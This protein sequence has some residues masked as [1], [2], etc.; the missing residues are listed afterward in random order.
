MCKGSTK[1]KLEAMVSLETVG[2]VWNLQRGEQDLTFKIRFLGVLF[3][4]VI[5]LQ[6]RRELRRQP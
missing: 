6:L 5:F 1:N 2:F 4:R 3:L